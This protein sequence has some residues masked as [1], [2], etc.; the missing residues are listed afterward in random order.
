MKLGTYLRNQRE[1]G[2]ITL[3][4]MQEKSGIRKN[5]IRILESGDFNELPDPNHVHFLLEK[6]SKVL[7]ID[8]DKLFSRF[9]D[10][11]PG[12]NEQSK[13]RQQNDNEDF[14]YLKKVLLSFGAMVAVIFVLWLILLQVGSETGAFESKP[15]YES[16]A[17]D[18]ASLNTEGEQD[19]GEE[20][21]A[22]EEAE[23][24]EE[25]AREE[26][27]SGADVS[28]TGMDDSTLFYEVTAE[29][30]LV[31][32]LEGENT[33]VSL[34]DDADNTYA[35]EELSEGEFEISDEASILYL[36]LG[37]APGQELTVG[38]ETVDSAS[39]TDAIT[40]HYQFTITRE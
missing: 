40:V 17:F 20:E 30:T 19:A 9:S 12:E 5:V 39:A 31:V 16:T 34:S 27:P 33:W 26:A 22:R 32:T 18:M 15:I 28:Y 23:S 14:N 36:T 38:G 35:Y 3:K 24:P 1:K 21:D 6:Y 37:N 11:L 25:E 8:T 29:D 10:E 7:G 2:G 4:E 13:K